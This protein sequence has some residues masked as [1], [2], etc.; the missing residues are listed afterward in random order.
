V[1]LSSPVPDRHPVV[2]PQRTARLDPAVHALPDIDVVDKRLPRVAR[3]PSGPEKREV[4]CRV[5]TERTQIPDPTD[6]VTEEAVHLLEQT[7]EVERQ[8]GG[9]DRVLAILGPSS[10]ATHH[11]LESVVGTGA[12]NEFRGEE[13]AP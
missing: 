8:A 10:G 9:R 6:L 7:P 13:A 1:R 3:L 2:H 4:P 5:R 11:V 12:V